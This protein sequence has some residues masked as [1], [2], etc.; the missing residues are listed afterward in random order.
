M[1]PG[2]LN[3]GVLLPRPEHG[4]CSYSAQVGGRVVTAPFTLHVT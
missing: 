3:V 4:V 2:K 1:T